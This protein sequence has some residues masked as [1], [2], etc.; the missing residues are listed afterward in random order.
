MDMSKKNKSFSLCITSTLRS[1][2]CYYYYYYKLTQYKKCSFTWLLLNGSKQT[3]QLSTSTC[4]LVSHQ[5][6]GWRNVLVFRD[7]NLFRMSC[8][9]RSWRCRETPLG[10]L[11]EL[12]EVQSVTWLVII[13]WTWETQTHTPLCHCSAVGPGIANVLGRWLQCWGLA[14][15]GGQYPTTASGVSTDTEAEKHCLN[16]CLRTL[17]LI[18]RS[19]V[20]SASTPGPGSWFLQ[21]RWLPATLRSVRPSI[22]RSLTT[23]W[24][25]L[26]AR[27]H[28][29]K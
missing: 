16:M 12:Q 2:Y 15:P 19:G 17:W 27:T 9:G 3:A 5:D 18:K 21:C 11:Q 10:S 14:P 8:L 25:W 23:A 20:C 29:S 7:D 1:L 26:P 4:W 6:L 28:I 22:D 13:H 24:A